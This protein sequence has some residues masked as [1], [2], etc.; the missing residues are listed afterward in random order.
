[1]VYDS[2]RERGKIGEYGLV[3]EQVIISL[4]NKGLKKA[5]K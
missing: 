4:W 3:N 2:R 5:I 1:M